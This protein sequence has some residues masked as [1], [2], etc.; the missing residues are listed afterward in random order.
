MNRTALAIRMLQIMKTEGLIKKQTLA[1]RLEIN[2]RNVIELKKELETA[3]YYIEVT[4]GKNGGYHLLDE[5]LLP[6]NALSND[7][8][9]AIKEAYNYLKA[10]DRYLKDSNFEMAFV[11]I[12]SNHM[13]VTRYD[14]VVAYSQL[15]TSSNLIN[16]HYQ[17]IKSAIKEQYRIKITY[18]PQNKDTV[19]WMFQ[20]YELFQY[21]GMWYLVGYRQSSKDL[22][23]KTITIKL[24]RIKK[25]ITTDVKFSF[26]S[27]FDIKDY[28]SKFGI[29]MNE[30]EKITVKIKG[31]YY[32]SEYLY[33]DGQTIEYLDDN[34]MILS[35]V[36]NT[37]L[38]MKQFV[39]SLGSDCEV[40]AP[41]WLKQFIIDE[42][43]KT[44]L[45]YNK[46]DR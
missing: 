27:Y 3:G 13:N 12:I 38:M 19:C 1:D 45:V 10:N 6:I 15:Q 9:S 40:I 25:I 36:M 11:K 34:T 8:I 30:Q 2:L 18:Q 21:N 28:V 31:R 24:N 4:N 41:D 5:Y 7:E 33:G 39:M 43:K 22:K 23:A 32:V 44:L 29:V 35:V 37:K 26:P 42:C 14:P 17:Q 20:P 16:K 46:K